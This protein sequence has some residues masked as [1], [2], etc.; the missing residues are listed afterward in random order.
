MDR[1]P[2]SE[3][4]SDVVSLAAGD[5]VYSA[6]DAGDALF[7]VEEG[8]VELLAAGDRRLAVLG[9]GDVF[10]EGA[11]LDGRPR[12]ETARA[13]T[14][15]RLV[16]IDAATLGALARENPDVALHMMR[17]LSRRLAAAYAA[18]T[19]VAAPPLPRIVHE[20]GTEFL[21]DPAGEIMIGRSDRS[22]RFTPPIDLAPLVPPDA[23]RSVSRRHAVIAPVSGVFHVRELPKVANGTWVNG[24]KLAP[25]TATPLADGDVI[26]FGPVKLAFR[27]R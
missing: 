23:P 25:D 1:A 22:S 14:A 7:V 17:R 4:G 13:L 18:A 24:V 12:D 5:A 10:G 8:A 15:C 27:Q 9:R 6:G 2:K 3:D 26:S 16:R 20:S 19:A 11:V 21:L